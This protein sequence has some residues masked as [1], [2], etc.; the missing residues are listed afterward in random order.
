M[1]LIMYT[2]LNPAVL[3]YLHFQTWRNSLVQDTRQDLKTVRALI[4]KISTLLIA[5]NILPLVFVFVFIFLISKEKNIA[6]RSEY[7]TANDFPNLGIH[8][9]TLYWSTSRYFKIAESKW[10]VVIA[11]FYKIQVDSTYNQ[12]ITTMLRGPRTKSCL[13]PYGDTLRPHI[14]ANLFILRWI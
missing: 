2:L 1:V 14:L 4:L 7:P 9:Y 8:F 13:E 12:I 6:K 11:N 10:L 5:C 3:K